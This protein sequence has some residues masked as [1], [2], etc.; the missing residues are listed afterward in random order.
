MFESSRT[1][2][3]SKLWW[4]IDR[5]PS[6]KCEDKKFKYEEEIWPIVDF[7]VNSHQDSIQEFLLRIFG[8]F[9]K[10][11]TGTVTLVPEIANGSIRDVTFT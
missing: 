3:V 11:F 6:F 7:L 2:T 5:D 9:R 4:E 10:I 1:V 8:N